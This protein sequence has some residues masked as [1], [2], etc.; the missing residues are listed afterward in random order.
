MPEFPE[1]HVVAL[2]ALHLHAA[3]A[4]VRPEDKLACLSDP[5]GFVNAQ[6]NE[7]Q[8]LLPR[9]QLQRL[10]DELAA[11]R[12]RSRQA[13]SEDGTEQPGALDIGPRL[14]ARFLAAL[15]E[16]GE[17]GAGAPASAGPEGTLA[18]S[19]AQKPA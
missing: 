4:L 12:E 3:S 13:P 2:T 11:V 16:L 19:V 5:W 10:R 8:P 6:L 9:D 7:S 14:A 17:T 18:T 15:G 1:N